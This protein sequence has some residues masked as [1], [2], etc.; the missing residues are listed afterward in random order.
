MNLYTY[1]GNSASNEVAQSKQVQDQSKRGAIV[2]KLAGK[3]RSK[4]RLAKDISKIATELL[5]VRY[6]FFL[7]SRVTFLLESQ[8]KMFTKSSV[9]FLLFSD[10]CSN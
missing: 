3:A 5:E 6:V 2:S 8:V 4:V 7:S 1:Q 9:Q 10:F